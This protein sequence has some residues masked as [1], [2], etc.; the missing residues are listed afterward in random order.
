MAVTTPIHVDSSVQE[1]W[2]KLTL[3][4]MLRGGFWAKFVG[5][6]GSR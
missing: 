4:D 1:L 6:E 3:R 2:A 5:G